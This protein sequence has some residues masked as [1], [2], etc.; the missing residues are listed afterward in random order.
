MPDYV[1][2]A[3]RQFQHKIR[4]RQNQPF[5][6]IPIEYGAKH[7]YAKEKPQSP[8]LDAKGKKYVQQVCRK[9]LFLG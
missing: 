8:K 5:P 1:K 3:L 9:F 6:H 7:Q 2:K 4:K